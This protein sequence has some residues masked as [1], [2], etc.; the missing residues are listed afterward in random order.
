MGLAGKVWRFLL[1]LAR[2][3]DRTSRWQTFRSDLTWVWTRFWMARAGPYPRGRT[4]TRLAAWVTPPFYGR[5]V[6][7]QL[8][9]HGYVAPAAVI[10]HADLRLG[11]HV[12]IGDRVTIVQDRDGGPVTLGDRV[13]L[14][15]DSYIQTGDGGSIEIGPDTHIQVRNQLSAYQARIRIGCRVQIAPNCAF[16]PY[17]HGIDR[18][19]RISDQP[20]TTKGDIV[21]DDDAWIGTGVT[22][23]S[24]VRIGRGAVVAAGSVVTRDVPDEAVV[25]GNPARMVK[26]RTRRS[27]SADA[28][29]EYPY[30]HLWSIGIY[31]GPSP[32]SLA[33][34]A[35]A[36]NPVLTAD[37]VSDVDAL[38]VADPFMARRDGRWFM[39]FEVMN[40]G[41]R[42][43]EIGLAASE[44]GFKWA[45]ERIVLAESFHLSYP[46]VF[47]WG[48]D[49][50]MIPETHQI[51]AVRLYKAIEFPTQWRYEATLLTGHPFSDSSICRFAGR[52]WLWTETSAGYRS[53]TLALYSAEHLTGPWREHPHSPVIARDARYARPAGRILV[54]GP[55]L[56][57]YAQDCSQVYGR[58]VTAHEIT[59]LSP[60]HYEER[61]FDPPPVLTGT[62][63]G[64]NA[65][66]MHHIDAHQRDDGEWLACVDGWRR[67]ILS[68]RHA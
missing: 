45:Y 23:L 5:K 51:Q 62:G 37:D 55:R 25:A 10:D 26:E 8:S 44:D 61:P 11:R 57:R 65:E 54:L 59:R 9:K 27:T 15:G 29:R 32:L 52:W 49:W 53:D 7:A 35:S 13:H 22:V 46:Y 47:E 19:Q 40:R 6:L 24:G 4:A 68:G 16:Y 38:F 50:Y 66:G 18:G 48:G 28:T 3:S 21:I 63:T 36:H 43:G 31:A 34:S 14:Y 33:P 39:F 42:R 2:P 30:E 58:H 1:R 20:L 41:R 67:P 17:D 60:A 56:L 12:F 64:W